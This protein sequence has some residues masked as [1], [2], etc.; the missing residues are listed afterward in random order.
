MSAFW[1]LIALVGVRTA[2]K[3]SALIFTMHIEWVNWFNQL[4]PG[5]RLLGKH[6]V[7]YTVTLW[8]TSLQVNANDCAQRLGNCWC[9][10]VWETVSSNTAHWCDVTHVCCLLHLHKSLSCVDQRL[11]SLKHQFGGGGSV[12]GVPL[13][14][15]LGVRSTLIFSTFSNIIQ[16]LRVLT[17]FVFLVP[18]T[19]QRHSF[20]SKEPKGLRRGRPH[21]KMLGKTF[22]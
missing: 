13:G 15:S 16:L 22:D 2:H 1:K 17:F 7:R 20:C 8:L 5:Y 21:T 6:Y 19:L 18:P 9:N 3:D 14:V 4:Y 11:S 12:C 10:C